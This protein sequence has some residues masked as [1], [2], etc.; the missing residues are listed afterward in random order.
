MFDFLLDEERPDDLSGEDEALHLL[1]PG[2][3]AGAA[4]ARHMLQNYQVG[5]PVSL[6]GQ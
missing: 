3:D 2:P 1:D 4:G 6:C 5:R